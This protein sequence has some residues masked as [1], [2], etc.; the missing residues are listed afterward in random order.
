ML[1]FRGGFAE[2]MVAVAFGGGCMSAV[3]LPVGLYEGVKE[4][5]PRPLRSEERTPRLLAAIFFVLW[6]GNDWSDV[7]KAGFGCGGDDARRLYK[8]LC[9]LK[10][11]ARIEAVVLG[12]MSRGR[13]R[14]WA[15]A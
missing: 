8:M 7:E 9:D 15:A 14:K 13:F 4:Y 2:E 3:G 1:N 10:T 5:L 12:E 11:W 6:G